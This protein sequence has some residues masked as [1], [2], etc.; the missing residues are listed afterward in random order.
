MIVRFLSV[1]LLFSFFSSHGESLFDRR[2]KVKKTKEKHLKQVRDFVNCCRP[3]R[4]VGT[5]GHAEVVPWLIE[6]IKKRDGGKGILRVTDFEPDLS[7]ASDLFESEFQDNIAKLYSVDSPQYKKWR[8]YTDQIL[9]HI[10]KQKGQRGKNIV[11]TRP[12]KG[13]RKKALILGTHYDQ[14]LADLKTGKNSFFGERGQGADD[15]GTG[16]AAL[17]KIIE[18]FAKY[19]PQH[20]LIVVFFDYGELGQLG[21]R[22]FVKDQLKTFGDKVILGFINPVMLGHDTKTDDLEKKYRNFKIYGRRNSSSREL[23]QVFAERFV[24]AGRDYT[25][26]IRFKFHAGGEVL[27]DRVAF[28]SFDFPVLTLSQNW[29]SDFNKDRHHTPNDF[30]ETL[31][32][33]TFY[34]SYLFILGALYHLINGV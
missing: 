18:F 6:E 5:R 20:D 23:D 8:S 4:I 34:Q 31:N 28:E 29:E 27:T 21:S 24:S 7:Y 15:N 12:G 22:A 17:L 9:G 3:N 16:V 1:F 30:V 26:G 10:K 11:W 14:A 33:K 2:Q 19:R 25:K 32:F 13:D